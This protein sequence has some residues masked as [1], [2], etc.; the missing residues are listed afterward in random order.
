MFT[1]YALSITDAKAVAAA[2][3]AEAERSK[4]TVTVAIVDDGGHLLYFERMDRSR[5]ATIEAACAKAK[6]A[7]LYRRPTKNYEEA[8]AGGQSFVLGVPDIA[9]VEG[10]L[11]LFYGG[12]SVGGIGISGAPKE[13]DGRIAA[14]GAAILSDL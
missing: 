9:P 7:A 5:L 14:V 11:P 4:L 10:G 12:N 13:D 3:I 8:V 2:A 6:T 1:K